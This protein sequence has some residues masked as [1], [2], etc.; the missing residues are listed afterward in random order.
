MSKPTIRQAERTTLHAVAARA[1]VS[2]STVS[3]VLADK[4][5][6]RGIS[7]TTRTRVRKVAEELNYAPNLLTR[8]LRRGRTHVL[9]F[10]SAFRKREEA[11]VYMDTLSSAIEM[12]GGEAGYDILVHCNF[13]RSP[14][15]IYQFLN[16]GLSDGLIL[17]APQPDDP[18]LALFHNSSLPVVVLNGR[19]PAHIFPSVADDVESGMRLIAQELVDKGHHRI[20]ILTAREEYSRDADKRVR[21]LREALQVHGINVPDQWVRPSGEDARV[22]LDKLMCYPEPPTAIYCWHDRLAYGTLACCESMGIDVPTQ[23]SIIG[24]DGLHWPSETRHLAAS[25]QLNQSTLARTAVRVL[26]EYI[27]GYEGPLREEVIPVTF[28]PGTSFGPANPLQRSNP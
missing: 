27:N 14:R 4:A 23:L 7:E 19:D 24:Y 17:F 8:S 16:G 20:A 25:I 11:D 12:A 10:Y 28:S 9:S 6:H 3:L 1:G 5:I 13:K 15:E 22:A 2:I 26:D 21:L 18:L